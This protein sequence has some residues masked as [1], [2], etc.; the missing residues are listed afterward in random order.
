VSGSV[1]YRGYEL[2]ALSPSG[3][4]IG[5]LVLVWAPNSDTPIIMPRLPARDAA[6][7]AAQSVVDVLLDIAV[8]SR[9]RSFR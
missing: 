9:R 2:A 5:W 6:I 1:I 3:A 7:E 8:P 4:E